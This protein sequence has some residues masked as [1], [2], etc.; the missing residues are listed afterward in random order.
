MPFFVVGEEKYGK[1]GEKRKSS[2]IEGS[3]LNG[4]GLKSLS[5]SR[6]N[7]VVLNFETL[8]GGRGCTMIS[9]V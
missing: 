6:V 1:S 2:E 7:Y 3:E 9:C 4:V 8:G 5:H